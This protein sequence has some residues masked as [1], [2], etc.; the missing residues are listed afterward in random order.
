MGQSRVNNPET[1]TTLAIQ[2]T[3]RTHKKTN[4]NTKNAEN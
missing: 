2:D 3:G 1:M 4:E